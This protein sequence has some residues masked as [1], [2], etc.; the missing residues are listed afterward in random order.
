MKDLLKSAIT[1]LITVIIVA[2]LPTEAEGEIYRDTLRLHILANSDSAE[3][4]ELKL[5]VRDFIL[6]EY[7]ERL[8]RAE[9][10]EDA[11]ATVA[12]LLCEIE[13]AAEEK[14]TPEG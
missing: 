11:T 4:Q 1:L 14:V 8:S 12:A 10:K 5:S 6:A 3:D 9:S 7:G 2:A 13:A